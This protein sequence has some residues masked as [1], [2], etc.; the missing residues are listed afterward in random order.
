MDFNYTHEQRL[1][2][3][4]V[5]RFLV[6]EHGFAARQAVIASGGG[7]SR[8]VWRHFADMGLLALPYAESMGGLGG[9][10][11]DVAIIGE[12][13]GEALLT[14][15]FLGSVMLGGRAL[16][17]AEPDARLIPAI[18]GMFTGDVIVALAHEEDFGVSHVVNLSTRLDSDGDGFVLSGRKSLVLAGGDAD[19]LVV[20]AMHDGQVALVAVDR[21]QA[22]V[23]TTP[24]ITIDGRSAAHIIFRDTPLPAASIILRDARDAIERVIDDASLYLCAESV[25]AMVALL[26]ITVDYART[27]Q[28][29]GA[30]IVAFQTIAHR[31][32][33]M[34][35]ALAKAQA[36]LAH[37][38]ALAEAGDA[39]RR[40]I[41]IVKAQT[42]RLGRA[43]A[44]NA[45]QTHGGVGMTDEL[46]VG[47]YLKR[48]L[49][50][51]ALFG[52]TEYH[53]RRLGEPSLLV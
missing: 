53:L 43:I 1:L 37:T 27:R 52:H 48:L 46:V 22:G 17:L 30:P 21:A 7:F 11:V 13:F 18:E 28:Q 10:V 8:P 29:F 45:V 32:A 35:I 14:E 3:D 41:S 51:E 40:D 26:R 6:K 2:A 12:C 34:K 23:E 42:G 44:E 24:F 15:P 36:T 20:S 16:C 5:G 39:S 9:S 47:H 25:G 31:L 19:V 33:D 50:N 4:N 49:A 38:L